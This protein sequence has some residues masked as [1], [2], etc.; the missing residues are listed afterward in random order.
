VCERFGVPLAAAAVQ[1]PLRHPAVTL[2][3]PGARSA[4]EIET[5][6]DFVEMAIPDELWA[7][8]DAV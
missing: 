4:A 5:D 3:L 1:F 6:L 8:L 2:V 7:E